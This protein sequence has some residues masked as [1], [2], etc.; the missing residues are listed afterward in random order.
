MT[1]PANCWTG[2]GARVRNFRGARELSPRVCWAKMPLWGLLLV[3][4]GGLLGFGSSLPGQE[5]PRPAPKK[6]VEQPANDK[7]PEQQPAEA[8]KEAEEKAEAE[9][10][11]APQPLQ[12]IIQKVLGLKQREANDNP[13]A[14]VEEG[15]EPTTPRDM[16]DQRAP[17]IREQETLLRSAETRIKRQ[18]W[19]EALEILQVLLDAEAESVVLGMDGQFHSIRWEAHERIG[20]LDP[21]ARRLYERTYGPLARR[22]L[23]DAAQASDLESIRQVAEQYFHTEAGYRAANLVAAYHLD[24][25]EF[26]IAARWYRR[27][28]RSHAEFTSDPLWRFKVAETY[29]RTAFEKHEFP[30]WLELTREQEIEL[31]RRLPV[32]SPE[33]AR[34]QWQQLVSSYH[35]PLRDWLYPGGT[36]NRAGH[37]EGTPPLLISQWTEPLVDHADIRGHVE[38]I[39]E[40]LRI[41]RIPS[42]PSMQPIVVGDRVIFRT[43]EGVRVVGLETGEVH[44]ETQEEFS[45]ARLLSS[46]QFRVPQTRQNAVRV[47]GRVIINRNAVNP[48][49][50]TQADQHPVSNL[51]F[52]D[53]VHGTLSSDGARVY[54]IEQNAILGNV[55][56][57]QQFGNMN[58]AQNDPF[59]R[60]WSSNRLTAYDLETGQQVWNI[61]GQLMGE[62]IDPPLA[63]TYFLGPPLAD[64]GELFVIGEQDNS[65]RLF[66]VQAETGELNWSQLLAFTDASIDRDVAR[67][68]WPAAVSLSEGVLVCPTNM[69]FVVGV[70]RRSQEILWISRYGA[71]V[72]ATQQQRQ[73]RGGGAI[74]IAS[75]MLRDRWF[76]TPPMIVGQTVVTAPPEEPILIGHRLADGSER[77]RIEDLKRGLYPLGSYN[78][79]ILVV[80]EE[81]LTGYSANTG[82][83]AWHVPFTDFDPQFSTLGT[84][85]GGRGLIMGDQVLL[86]INERE[87]WYFDLKSRKFT[88]R[89]EVS[90]E[91]P[92]LG[93]LVMAQ[94]K[95]ISAGPLDVSFFQPKKIIEDQITTR[96]AEDPRDP[97][98]LLKKVQVLNLEQ[99]Y[100]ESLASLR[101]LPADSLSDSQTAEFQRRK[102]ETI[103]GLVRNNPQSYEAEFEEL[104][105]LL[106]TAEDR[107]LY[108]RLKAE[109][110]LARKDLAGAFAA[111]A[112]LAEFDGNSQIRENQ[113]LNLLVRQDVWLHERLQ[114]L[115]TVSS[116][117]VSGRISDHVRQSVNKVLQGDELSQMI[118]LVRVFGFHPEVE[119]VYF[120][121]V[122]L[123]TR[124][125]N[126]AI[127][128]FALNN[129]AQFE[130][131]AI[132]ATS[133]ALR[134]ELLRDF[135]L[136]EDAVHFADQL[137]GYD[138]ELVLLDGLT[139]AEHLEEIAREREPESIPTPRPWSDDAYE[140]VPLGTSSW[141]HQ[142]ATVNMDYSS[143]PYF[144]RHRFLYEH[145]S[146]RLDIFRR[147]DDQLVWSIPLQQMDQVSQS[148]VIPIR[149]DGYS[150]T[151]YF[152]GMVQCYSLPDQRLV[153]ARAITSQPGAANQFQVGKH[154]LPRF[155]QARLASSR[156]RLNQHTNEYGPLAVITPHSI[157][158]F[159]RNELIAVDPLDG[160]IRWIR[161]GIPRGTSVYG[162]GDVLCVVTPSLKDSYLLR[163]NDGSLV[164]SD[165]LELL[166]NRG[167]A[168]HGQDVISIR[169]GNTHLLGNEE[170]RMLLAAENLLTQDIR[171]E[172]PLSGEDQLALIDPKTLVVV[173]NN[174]GVQLVDL[175]TGERT[176]SAQVDPRVVQNHKEMHAFAEGNQLFLLTNHATSHS[177]YLNIYNQ[178]L[179]G[180]IVA[181][182]LQ[183]GEEQWSHKTPSLSLV[184][185]DIRQM[186][187]FVLAGSKHERKHNLYI[188]VFTVQILDK[189]TGIPILDD[190]F[191]TQNQ[192]QRITWNALRRQ[193][194]LHA[195]N[196]IY[197][198]Q[199]RQQ[200]LEDK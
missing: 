149:M 191:M 22:V 125:G 9:K 126:F 91:E 193:L 86:P 166:I 63:G 111:Y 158:Y 104:T 45:P 46:S 127:A 34:D 99:Q 152:R 7:K 48:Y 15:T 150:I 140:V 136:Y 169:T 147:E 87:L 24:Q 21:V 178:R 11:P 175:E 93:N 109:R 37:A 151:I 156:F 161:R 98:G 185:D 81:G 25:G 66:C 4:C 14:Q 58:A 96:L 159:G 55:S 188:G 192:V 29:R 79:E 28:E 75:G 177:T 183:T 41:G 8:K 38:Q 84:M 105:N 3:L 5:A 73:F 23:D 13:P 65:L 106:P 130:D 168:V 57:G 128:E 195:Y 10:K 146:G 112:E 155:Q 110:M 100:E 199:P 2:L 144:Q 120:R 116:G 162:D 1:D 174:G 142:Q 197:A 71:R 179:S 190:S 56:P 103:I 189:Q 107:Q 113:D 80:S 17:L 131:E 59:R 187:I 121:M 139:V 129:M 119:D 141:S 32:D 64:R 16:I 49:Y 115:W 40:D 30:D 67:R 12:Q 114:E 89:A 153:W 53:G 160:E 123:A 172:I 173:D 68:W 88:S 6:A 26:A 145:K 39:L 117:T 157:C 108:L 47:R 198:I 164:E 137:R 19:A 132:V 138:P 36:R 182:D 118:K 167:I 50:G 170:G 124:E 44:W 54:V 101:Q 194:Y 51:L 83:E 85:P 122:E 97:W 163:T 18:Q 135:Q 82:E 43:F 33:A 180:Y 31:A 78:S 72:P 154:R 77:W 27:L 92:A 60:D 52:R 171:W 165:Q 134:A 90:R 148:N 20:R 181:I 74:F 76:P 176:L 95:L 184:L 186:P 70:D 35:R 69:G 42:I 196:T 94:G 61:G 62:E 143:L 200:V 102:L 133:L